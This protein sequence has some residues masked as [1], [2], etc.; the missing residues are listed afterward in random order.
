MDAAFVAFAVVFLAELG[1]KTQLVA[2]SLATR[3]RVSLVLGGIF[4]AFAVTQGFA[5]LVGGALG[6]ALPETAVGVGA[7][8]IFFGF[9]LWTW[10]D[11][12]EDEDAEVTMTGRHG[13]RALAAI[14]AT[15]SVAE[16]GDKTMLAT[17]TLA[18]DGNPLWTWVGGTF[19]A[20]A[21]C[22]LGVGVGRLLGTRLPARTTKRMAAVLFAVF[23]VLLLVDA[24][25]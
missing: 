9:A 19:G 20:T 5:A 21:S 12:D 11:A 23:G 22:L 6:A 10:R 1:D 15:M 13:L 24:L 7:A 4:V 8:I 17:T 2:L 16:L 25:R 14:I 18:A 3:H